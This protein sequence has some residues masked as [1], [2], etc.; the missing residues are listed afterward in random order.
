MLDSNTL[1]KVPGTILWARYSF[2][3]NRLKYCG[4]DANLDLFERASRKISDQKLREILSEFEAA[5]PYIQFIANENKIEDPFDWKVVEAYWL[6]NDLLTKVSVSKFYRHLE[7]HFGNRAK[8]GVLTLI[9]NKLPKG[10]KPH[11]SFH[12]LDVYQK[13]GS[14]R[15]V[16]LGPAIETINNCLIS[17]GRVIK[18]DKNFLEVEYQPLILN[19]KLFFG[20]NQTKKIDY[21]FQG[22]TLL[23]NPQ[24][25]DWVSIH[26]NWACDILTDRQ[27]KNLQK[28]TLWHLRIA[29][30][31]I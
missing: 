28:W 19:K 25:G 3:P 1:I 8:P 12:V 9:A 22:K 17:W 10:A 13:V 7:D 29:N 16:N 23:D 18:I 5:F 15:G 26:W 6:G 24:I 11:H 14:M 31:T 27:L 30:Q 20:P 4:P 21:Q 2:S